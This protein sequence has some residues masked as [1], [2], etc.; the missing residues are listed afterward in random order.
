MLFNY[1]DLGWLSLSAALNFGCS[2]MQCQETGPPGRLSLASTEPQA[3]CW[4]K[5]EA[6]LTLWGRHR[7]SHKLLRLASRAERKPFQ[8]LPPGPSPAFTFQKSRQALALGGPF[9]FVTKKEPTQ[10]TRAA[11]GSSHV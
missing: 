6:H 5:R 7:F 1:N 4:A 8:P 11:F 3:E 2:G 9:Y 10:R